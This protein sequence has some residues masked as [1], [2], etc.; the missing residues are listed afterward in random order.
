MKT[1][2]ILAAL[3]C[4]LGL[5]AQIPVTDVANLLSNQLA[6]VENIAKWVDSISQLRTQIEH[7]RQQIDIQKDIRQWTGNP[8]EAGGA[9]LLDILG[10]E[11]LVRDFGRTQEAIRRTVDSVQSL[12]NTSSGTYRAITNLDLEGNPMQRDPLL[13]RRF[14]VLDATRENT[15]VVGQETKARERELQEEVALTLSEI[16]SAPTDAEVQKLAA[17]LNALNGQLA[18][19]E[20]TRQREVDAVTIQKLAND[21][22]QEEERLAAAELAARDDYLANLRVTNY[23]KNVRV[24]RSSPDEL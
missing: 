3:L 19:V 18:Q 23:M 11:D 6:H 1:Y 22:R 2:L 10:A 16:K 13:Y 15:E 4:P 8:V 9:L 17:K 20:N 14:S 12:Q 5:R 21:A 24:R 7:L